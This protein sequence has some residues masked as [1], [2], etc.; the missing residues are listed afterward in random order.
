MNSKEMQMRGDKYLHEMKNYCLAVPGTILHRLEKP[1]ILKKITNMF[2]LVSKK[3]RH[4][5][6]FPSNERAEYKK[7][8]I[9]KL[10]QQVPENLVITCAG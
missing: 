1:V 10:I 9:L 4:H 3:Y 5:N 8:R 7:F 6:F 2:I